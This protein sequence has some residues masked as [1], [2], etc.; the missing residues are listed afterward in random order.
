[1]TPDGGLLLTGRPELRHTTTSAQWSTETIEHHEE[2]KEVNQVQR[3]FKSS[4]QTQIHPAFIAPSSEMTMNNPSRTFQIQKHHRSFASHNAPRVQTS[5]L[6]RDPSY[7][8]A[9]T[10]KS[11]G[12]NVSTHLIVELPT[13]KVLSS[14]YKDGSQ[15]LSSRGMESESV[16]S[17]SIAPEVGSEQ[18]ES[19]VLDLDELSW[20]KRY[21]C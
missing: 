1:M 19:L 18:E 14:H 6:G 13:Q 7:Y 12:D 20:R 11:P 8:V 5:Q 10:S 17:S 15:L 4:N 16:H 21:Q 9:A 2:S 3:I